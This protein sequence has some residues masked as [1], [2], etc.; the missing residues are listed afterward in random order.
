MPRGVGYGTGR[1]VGG[2]FSALMMAKARQELANQKSVEDLEEDAVNQEITS[3]TEALASPLPDFLLKKPRKQIAKETFAKI[4]PEAFVKSFLAPDKQKSVAEQKAEILEE[5]LRDPDFFKSFVN[6]TFLGIGEKEPERAKDITGVGS[7][8]ATIESR[9]K[10]TE[11]AQKSYDKKVAY[12]KKGG[13]GTDFIRENEKDKRIRELGERPPDYQIP[14]D[15]SALADSVE[16]GRIDPTVAAA[17]AGF[18]PLDSEVETGLDAQ[19]DIL[20]E[21]P[22]NLVRK[23]RKE[24]RSDSEMIEAWQAL[25]NE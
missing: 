11:N 14:K 25:K 19:Q 7:L 8:T 17:L 10:E 18:E 23:F 21:I 2:F 9:I 24:G 20:K 6:K 13:S 12:I 3:A 16:V 5:Q 15:I 1:G 22:P 4:D